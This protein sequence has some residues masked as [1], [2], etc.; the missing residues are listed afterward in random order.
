[1]GCMTPSLLIDTASK[2]PEWL[3]APQIL[4]L[5]A[6]ATP[7]VVKEKERFVCEQSF[8]PEFFRLQKIGCTVTTTVDTSFGF[9]LFSGTKFKDEN[10]LTFHKALSA[11]QP[12]GTFLT[13]LPN[14]LGAGRFEKILFDMFE[15]EE[16]TY[17][18]SKCRVFGV[19]N[20]KAIRPSKHI[21]EARA[22]G[23]TAGTFN[24]AQIDTG[25]KL[26]AETVTPLLEG[27]GADLGG[28]AG[29]LS[30]FALIHNA[31]ITH[32][33]LYEAE[34]KALAIAEQ[35]LAAL[36]AKITLHWSDVTSGT[37]RERYDWVISNPPF[38]TQK[39]S[40]P[41]LGIQFIKA[42]V[43]SLKK[44]GALYIV[45]NK[46]LPYLETAR[47]LGKVQILADQNGF[48][49]WELRRGDPGSNR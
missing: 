44:N 49:V 30:H 7:A 28:G 47:S 38:H 24:A 45:Q 18:K 31:K 8:F 27:D 26:L 14:D 23:A 4:Y 1:M 43:N 22:H 5:R 35:T 13:I 20:F 9:I 32:I 2:L 36:S 42:G 21:D 34:K 25:S 40:E 29:Y 11:L 48:L 33:D 37:P 46:H 39:D 10:I 15:G 17:S 6:H 3:A 19:R 41:N 16:F 12:G